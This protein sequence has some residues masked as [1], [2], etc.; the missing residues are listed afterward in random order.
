MHKTGALRAPL[1]VQ[2]SQLLHSADL[3]IL[4][5][6]PAKAEAISMTVMGTTYTE[7][8]KAGEAIIAACKTMTDLDQKMELGEYRGFPMVLQIAGTT[9]LLWRLGQKKFIVRFCRGIWR[10]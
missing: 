6:Y 9:R 8:K 4:K 2:R 3:P 10:N 5:A 7:R 1:E